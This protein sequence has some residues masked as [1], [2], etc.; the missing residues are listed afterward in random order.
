LAVNVLPVDMKLYFKTTSINKN[1]I[2][3]LQQ[4]IF[5]FS[6][7]KKQNQIEKTWYVIINPAA[8]NSVAAKRWS[9]M[10][11]K[12]D[13]HNILY[14]L[15]ETTQA[16][17]AIDLAKEGIEKGYRQII[18]VGGDGT[19]NEVVN[20]IFQQKIVS[21]KRISYTLLPVGTGNDWA[22]M[23]Q[24]PKKIDQWFDYFQQG[25][26]KLQD[27]GLVSYHF[28]GKKQK[29]YFANVAGMA[30]DAF[31]CKTAEYEN[32]ST[33]NSLLY[34]FLIFKCL[35]KYKLRKARV[36]FNDQVVEDYFY[37]INV[38]ICRYSG[39]GMSFVPHA[40][41]FDGKLALTLAR[42]FSKF[43]VILNAYRF[44]TGSIDDLNKAS[45]HQTK[46]IKIEAIDD[47]ATLVEVDGEYIGETP[48]EYSILEK[49]LKV[50]VT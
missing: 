15:V 50:I 22:K 1:H 32:K 4:T 47:E 21:P 40:D 8:G 35:F 39:G 19:N 45:T 11:K 18:A 17:H 25:K 28:E 14:K 6:K 31:I 13:A 26:S 29:R 5:E 33:S 23:H 44:Y 34:L 2:S 3:W 48:V 16:K 24:I 43:E 46:H 9:L 36:S 41:P 49:T 38:G 10:A 12:F 30:Y 20:G 7:M 42:N 27:I 37:T